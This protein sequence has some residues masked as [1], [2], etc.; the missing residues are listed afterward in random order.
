MIMLSNLWFMSIGRG[1]LLQLLCQ[2]LLPFADSDE[3]GPFRWAQI[4][5]QTC[6][7]ASQVWGPVAEEVD[8]HSRLK[9]PAALWTR[10]W[11]QVWDASP[12]ERVSQGRLTDHS[13]PLLLSPKAHC[14]PG[15][16]QSNA[17]NVCSRSLKNIPG[18]SEGPV[19][20]HNIVGSGIGH[21]CR[22]HISA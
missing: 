14:D 3:R 6:T 7:E 18:K 20:S 22:Y 8:G 13:I 19:T 17:H 10:W 12:T 9:G 5:I 15:L 16:V 4:P 21:R 2:G 1:S 11:Q